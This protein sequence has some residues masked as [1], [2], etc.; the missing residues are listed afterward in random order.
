MVF[1]ATA[2]NIRNLRKARHLS[3]RALGDKSGVGRSA[4]AQYEA[5]RNEPPLEI[6]RKLA[7]ALGT[8][9]AQL[10]DLEPIP[11]SAIKTDGNN[12]NTNLGR[13]VPVARAGYR[14][15]PVYGAITAG[16]PGSSYSDVLEWIELPEWG[17][18]QRWGR[19]IEGESMSPEFEPEDVAIF[20][21]R[22]WVHGDGVH[23]F[24]DGE[25]VFKIAWKESGKVLLRPINRS[26]PDIDA[27][28]WQIKGVCIKR[29]R[30]LGRGVTDTREYRSGFKWR[31]F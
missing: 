20:E 14:F 5:G 8:T 16:L 3:Q 2:D 28:D 19:V 6:A 31:E 7:E 15:V 17:E 4:I 11:A 29:I 30:D 1:V 13:E 9:P 26:F 27:H 12:P 22:A 10:L 24:K 25:D 18:F 23:A 21:D